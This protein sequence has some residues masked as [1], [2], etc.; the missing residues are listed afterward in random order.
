MTESEKQLPKNAP[1]PEAPTEKNG[2][3]F[4]ENRRRL[5][6]GGMAAAPVLMTLASRPVLG[7]GGDTPGECKTPSG[8]A[9]GNVS[10]HGTPHY[11]SGRTPGYWKAHLE[12]WPPP[13]Y[14][15]TTS[16][17]GGHTA[18]LFHSPTTGLNGTQFPGKTML[19]VLN[20]GGGDYIALARHIVAALLNAKAG[21][22]PP[23]VLSESAVRDI[24][25]SYVAK[26]YYEPTAGIKWYPDDIVTYLLTTM[27]I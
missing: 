17:P 3:D 6:K 27:P 7:G 11:C 15:T 21:L 4:K 20:M 10:Q 23:E 24:W 18:T 22:V 19:E 14:P 16:G 8:F 2:A 5:L 25:N 9:S 12:A 13:Y 26:G 1:S